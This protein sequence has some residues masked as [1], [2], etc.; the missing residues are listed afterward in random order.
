M[1]AWLIGITRHRAIDA[2]RSRQSRARARE[3]GLDRANRS[4]RDSAADPMAHSTLRQIVQQALGA[5]SPGEREVI[6]LAY[7]GGLTRVEIAAQ[8]G[9]PLGTVKSRLWTALLKL[10]DVLQG[11]GVTP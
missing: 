5:L 2:T 10:R 4:V 3:T 1:I 9:Q 8:L 7:Y 6:A 11:S